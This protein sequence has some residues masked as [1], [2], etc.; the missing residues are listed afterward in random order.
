M[1]RQQTGR[2]VPIQL[3]EAIKQEVN[4]LLHEGHIVKVDEIK[5]DVHLQPTVITVKKDRSVE[6]ALDGEIKENVLKNNYQMR[7]FDNIMAMIA[8]NVATGRTF[9]TTL[10][11]TNA[12]GQVEQGNEYSKLVCSKMSG[13]MR[14]DLQI[15][16]E[17]SR[18]HHRAN[19]ISTNHGPHTS[20]YLTHSLSL[21]I[22]Q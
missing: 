13:V 18:P 1:P 10:D 15:R 8:Q 5:E 9:F 14:R 17:I 11:M 3:Q 6:T 19:G 12:Y 4:R 22:A 21:M 2:C 16:N 7:N 20:M